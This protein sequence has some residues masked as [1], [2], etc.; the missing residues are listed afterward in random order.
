[1]LYGS[2][3]I[4]YHAV[5]MRERLAD[6]DNEYN[7]CPMNN[8]PPAKVFFRIICCEGN[9]FESGHL[10]TSCKAKL[11]LL[12]QMTLG[13]CVIITSQLLLQYL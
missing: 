11:I 3:T 9:P 8:N 7:Q 5:V 6:Y 2:I 13:S 1:M 10:L 12:C 4:L